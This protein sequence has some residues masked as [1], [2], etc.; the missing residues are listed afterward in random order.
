MKENN[1]G[2]MAIFEHKSKE[3][4]TTKITQKIAQGWKSEANY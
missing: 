4:L 3:H 1:V 2:V